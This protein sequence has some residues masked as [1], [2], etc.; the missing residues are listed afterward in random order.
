[1]RTGHPSRTALSAARARATHQI[2]DSPRI[3]TDPLAS[4]LVEAAA[5]DAARGS[6]DIDRTGHDDRPFTPP[7]VRRYTPREVRLYMVMRQRFAEDTLVAAA[8]TGITQVVILGAGLDTFGYRN[9]GTAVFEV[10]HPATQVWKQELLRRADI[11]VPPSLHYV[12]IDFE[13][14]SSIERLVAA[15]FNE[16]IPACFVCLGVLVYLTT[17]TAHKILRSVAGLSAPA[18]IVF[19]YTEP[20]WALPAETRD[21][22]D[23]L[24]A[25]MTER[26]EPWRTFFTPPAIARDLRAL[27]FTDIEDLNWEDMLARY[28]QGAPE[29]NLLGGHVL[30]AAHAGSRSPHNSFDG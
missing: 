1:M 14:D 12:P 25:F 19:D 5:L 30:R 17:D 8:A 6:P 4:S 13:T 28:A 23:E 9:P 2:E 26:G 21:V 22:V 10:D 7:D 29:A 16:S 15:G 20:A 27:G 18:Q 3:F 24:L 11:P